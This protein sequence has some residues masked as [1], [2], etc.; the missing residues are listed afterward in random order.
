[1]TETASNLSG[2]LTVTDGVHTA[3]ITPFGQYM[4]SQFTSASDGHG[5]III[6]DPTAAAA[7]SP[8]VG[9]LTAPHHA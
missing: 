9:T 4:A 5:G 2:T 3:N 7:N 6:G 8:N 1:L